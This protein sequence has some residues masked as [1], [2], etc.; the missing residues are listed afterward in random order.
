MHQLRFA[1]LGICVAAAAALTG[2]CAQLGSQLGYYA[3]AA[4]GQFSLLA[5]ARPI[6]D[7]LESLQADSPLRKKLLQAQQIRQFAA[8]ELSL[9]DNRSYTSYA[10]LTQPFVLWNVVAT[11][12]LSME[13]KHWCFP[14]AGCVSYRGYYD[15]TDAQDYA[16]ALRDE[17]FDVQV[18]GVPAYSTLGWFNDPVLSSFIQYP[19]GEFARLVFHELAH[20][21]VYVKDDTQFNE[22]FATA[23]EEM[24]VERWLASHG[25]FRLRQ[26]YQEFQSRKEDFLRLLLKHRIILEENYQR[27]ASDA[28]KLQRKQDIFRQLRDDYQLLRLD[29][30]GY[31]GYDRW[32][33]EPL[34][35]AHLASVATYHE[36]VPAFRALLDQ[37]KSLPRFYAAASRLADLDK[38]ARRGELA[39]ISKRIRP[40][41][42]EAS[43]LSL[44]LTNT[45][46]LASPC[47]GR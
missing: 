35:N 40:V 29:W 25:D 2:G 22:S 11:G 8:R 17:G 43:T 38:V 24:G 4:H 14:V 5:S 12:P 10:Q 18:G 33:A 27:V 1:R 15:K 39:A 37:E 9:P 20:Q 28:E 47:G 7:W 45:K 3:Q 36:F 44:T 46:C 13:Q 42:A 26:T 19:Q 23:V 32:F 16:K 21:V 41:D 34:S 30:G 31:A 6:N